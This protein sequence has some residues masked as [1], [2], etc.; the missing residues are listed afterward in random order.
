[1]LLWLLSQRP[2]PQKK[3][4]EKE[5]KKIMAP[6]AKG[7]KGSHSN[8]WPR[9]ENR[10]EDGENLSFFSFPNVFLFFPLFCRGNRPMFCKVFF[11]VLFPAREYNRRK[12]PK[13]KI[14]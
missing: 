7:K 13:A 14:C 11:S 4:K 2:I 6:T 10:G 3:R 8:H 5:K 9:L 12:F 1:M